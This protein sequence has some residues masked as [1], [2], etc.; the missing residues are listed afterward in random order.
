M[1]RPVLGEITDLAHPYFQTISQ[2][3][4]IDVRLRRHDVL[5]PRLSVIP[6]EACPESSQEQ[7]SR[8]SDE[9]GFRE[10]ETNCYG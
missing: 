4:L 1:A 9:E 8:L 3:A 5:V 2:T 6:V 7:E 10:K